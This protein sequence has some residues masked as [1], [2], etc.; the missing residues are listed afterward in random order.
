[1]AG[2]IEAMTKMAHTEIDTSAVDEDS[3]DVVVK[4]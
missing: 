4:C 1:M 3:D 2:T